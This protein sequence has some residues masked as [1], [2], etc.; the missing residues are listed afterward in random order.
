MQNLS[1][2]RA[3]E[4]AKKMKHI[5]FC[6]VCGKYTMKEEHCGKRTIVPRPPKYSPDDKYADYRRKAKEGM[7][8]EK[9]LR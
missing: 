4:A 8:K 9:G 3:S 5:M 6:G 2:K 7:L 1:G